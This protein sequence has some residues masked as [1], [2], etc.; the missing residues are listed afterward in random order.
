M[1]S[2]GRRA[3][4]RL[5]RDAGPFEPTPERPNPGRDTQLLLSLKEGMDGKT[6]LS[7][8]AAYDD[9]DGPLKGHRGLL[10]G[11]RGP[12]KGPRGPLKGTRVL[13]SLKIRI[14]SA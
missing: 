6:L 7:S 13:F 11:P 5:F 1:P 10:K 14:T 9:D 8:D 12:F 3:P 4:G 2:W